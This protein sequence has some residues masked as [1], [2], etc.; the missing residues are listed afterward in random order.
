MAS[1]SRLHYRA[2]SKRR[3]TNS[4]PP[5]PSGKSAPSMPSSIPPASDVTFAEWARTV[6]ATFMVMVVIFGLVAL[7][8][9]AWRAVP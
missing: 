9:A 7:F 5:S 1:I 3:P 2:R 8:G 4:T 6:V